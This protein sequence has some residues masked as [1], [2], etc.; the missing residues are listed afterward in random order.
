M[1]LR[2]CQFL[3]L[4][5]FLAACTATPQAQP[6]PT[7][8]TSVAASPPLDD[9]SSAMMVDEMEQKWLALGIPSYRIEVQK[10]SI[11]E[12]IVYQITV[13]ENVVTDSSAT[14]KPGPARS[15]EKECEAPA[16]D[17]NDYTVPALFAMA[18]EQSVGEIVQWSRIEYDPTYF[19]PLWITYDHPKAIDEES[20]WHV[21]SFTPD[22]P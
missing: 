18:R 17:P 7:E 5:V 8:T 12:V 6:T 13:K 3:I 14:C 1:L 2:G 22:S 10:A 4:L 15:S 21:V 20:A 9:P 16:F 19:F 11:R